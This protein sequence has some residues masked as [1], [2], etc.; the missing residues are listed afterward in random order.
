[1]YFYARVF[2]LF[3]PI[4]EMQG[5][6][7]VIHL[8]KL[9]LSSNGEIITYYIVFCHMCNKVAEKL[10]QPYNILWKMS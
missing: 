8:A 4:Y 1:M 6:H 9:S 2:L 5:L 7:R 3:A 10:I